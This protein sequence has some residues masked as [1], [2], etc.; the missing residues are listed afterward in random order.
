MKYVYDI[1]GLNCPKCAEKVTAILSEQEG[2]TAAKANFL[3]GKVSVESDLSEAE[4]FDLVSAGVKK[5]S[6]R[7]A[8]RRI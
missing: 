6:E 7:A 8:I 1:E 5:F 4:V 2:L 3:T